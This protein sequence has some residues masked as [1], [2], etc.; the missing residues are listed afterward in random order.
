MMMFIEDADSYMSEVLQNAERMLLNGMAMARS[1]QSLMDSAKAAESLQRIRA[2][3]AVVKA[4]IV[5]QDAVR[6]V[7]PPVLEGDGLKAVEE[8]GFDKPIVAEDAVAV[9]VADRSD[10]GR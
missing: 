5:A 8:S 3:W 10:D 2:E 7:L 1:A 4:R 9:A 6:P